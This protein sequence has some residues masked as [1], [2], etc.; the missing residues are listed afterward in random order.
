MALPRLK[1]PQPDPAAQRIGRRGHRLE[2]DELAPGRRVQLRARV[3]LEELDLDSSSATGHGETG[4][5]R[6]R[7]EAV[8]E[9]AFGELEARLR[10]ERSGTER[11]LARIELEAA[12]R[13]QL[14][15]PALAR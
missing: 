5:F 12:H 10:G 7:V 9:G 15:L 8:V 13:R 14:D 6:E 11:D 2:A 3:A 4:R 1:Q